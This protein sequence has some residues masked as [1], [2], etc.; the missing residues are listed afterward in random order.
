MTRSATLTEIT[1][2]L[3]S[4][5]DERLAVVADIVK[6]MDEPNGLVRP[7]S[8]REQ[9]LVDTSKQDFAAGRAFSHDE[10]VALLDQHLAARGVP[11]S[12]P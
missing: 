2:K 1:T 7:L 8:P 12:A 10:V 4:F 3:A 11:K 5:D 9:A 6:S